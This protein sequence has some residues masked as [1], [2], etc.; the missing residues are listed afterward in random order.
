MSDPSGSLIEKIEAALIESLPIQ[1]DDTM[2]RHVAEC[3][4]RVL[5]SGSSVD[6]TTLPA[7][8]ARCR[9]IAAAYPSSY[10]AA[11]TTHSDAGWGMSRGRFDLACEF[12][13]LIAGSASFG[14]PS[15]PPSAETPYQGEH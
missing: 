10:A 5:A 9:E 1:L 4:A 15:A 14:S 6:A 12:L 13:T 3:V 11:V 7:I 2:N 8:E